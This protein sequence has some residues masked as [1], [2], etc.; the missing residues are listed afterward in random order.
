MKS[1]RKIASIALVVLSALL[2]FVGCEQT[3]LFEMPQSIKSGVITQDGEFLEGQAFDP[4]KFTVEVVYDNGK[5]DSFPGASIVTWTPSEEAQSGVKSGDSLKAKVG[6][7]SG[8][9]SYTVDGVLYA[10]KIDTLTVVP[11]TTS[12]AVNDWSELDIPSTDVAV[13]ATFT[14]RDGEVATVVLKPSEYKIEVLN[15]SD[16]NTPSALNPSV[17]AVAK[18]TTYVGGDV[19]TTYE[20]TGTFEAADVDFAFN[21]ITD[22]SLK[23][24]AKLFGFGDVVADFAL[25]DI[26]VSDGVNDSP[27]TADPGIKLSFVNSEH[28]PVT[29]LSKETGVI[30][31]AEYEGCETY[32]SESIEVTDVNLDVALASDSEVKFYKGEALPEISASDY[33]VKYSYSALIRYVDSSDVEFA[34]STDSSTVKAPVDGVVPEKDNLYVIATYR[35]ISKAVFLKTEDRTY[36][37]VYAPAEQS[38]TVDQVVLEGYTAPGAQNY[39]EDLVETIFA[40]DDS[41]V[42][43]VS[44]MYTAAKKDAKPEVRVAT[45]TALDNRIEV[46]YTTDTNGTA[47]VAGPDALVGLDTIYIEVTYTPISGTEIVYYEPVELQTAYADWLD[48]DVEY[49]TMN[50]A[51]TSPMFGSDVNITVNAVNAD[52]IVRELA[53]DEYNILGENGKPATIDS[54]TAKEQTFTINALVEGATGVKKIVSGTDADTPVDVTI[55]AGIAYTTVTDLSVGIKEGTTISCL[56]DKTWDEV[57]LKTTDFVVSGYEQNGTENPLVVKEFVYVTEKTS[58]GENTVYARVEY[59]NAEGEKVNELVDFTIEGTAWIEEKTT[60]TVTIGGT[61]IES[62]EPGE[63]DLRNAVVTGLEKHGD[64]SWSLSAVANN[65]SASVSGNTFEFNSYGSVTVTL[66]WFDGAKVDSEPFSVGA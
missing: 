25:F 49:S 30:V 46:K 26:T 14:G 63:Y 13:T 10:A 54:V 64:I 21:E 62:L 28:R 48:V 57:A 65:G 35:G 53:E 59:T 32:Y 66:S 52:G 23:D 1:A 45:G 42:K 39:K 20:I 40:L 50:A 58:Y 61:D 31:K 36:E 8:N 24:G 2:V 60:P 9:V 3:P 7:D 44:Y 37:A 47:L 33:E 17:N 11:A 16:L 19:E 4:S 55:E 5:T 38:A 41:V 51:K 43:S 22:I 18:I 34:Y 6:L 15:T 27:L 56:A 29:D 12:Y